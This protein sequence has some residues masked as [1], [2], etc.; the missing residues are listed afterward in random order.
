MASVTSTHL[1]LAK[2][3]HRATLKCRD[4]EYI[5]AGDLGEVL[6]DHHCVSHVSGSL[7]LMPAPSHHYVTNSESC[8]SSHVYYI[9][10]RSWAPCCLVWLMALTINQ[11]G[12]REHIDEDHVDWIGWWM[13]GNAM[14]QLYFSKVFGLCLD[15]WQFIENADGCLILMEHLPCTRPWGSKG[16]SDHHLCSLPSRS[17]QSN[18]GEQSLSKPHAKCQRDLWDLEGLG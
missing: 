13:L 3:S 4:Q 11:M 7:S 5:F 17:L 8:S 1:S 2:G 9:P 18:W 15:T 10:I 12:E 6:S 14:G 16:K